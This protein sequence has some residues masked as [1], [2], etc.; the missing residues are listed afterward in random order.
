MHI[1]H[2]LGQFTQ[3]AE[4]KVFLHTVPQLTLGCIGSILSIPKDVKIQTSFISFHL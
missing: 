2:F 4:I 3:A 1:F